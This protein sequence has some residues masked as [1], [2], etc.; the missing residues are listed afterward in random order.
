LGRAFAFDRWKD[1]DQ[2]AWQ[3]LY[4]EA[5]ARAERGR[6]RCPPLAGNDRHPGAIAIARRALQQ[7]QLTD[8]IHLDE[9]D[10]RDWQPPFAPEYVVSNPPYGERLQSDDG[11]LVDSW[12]SLGNFLHG[13]QGSTAHV[14]C[15]DASLTRHLGLR[16]ERKFPV[17]N[18][19]IECRWLRYEVGGDDEG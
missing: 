10:A 5:E 8:R 18:G 4:D 17:R 11:T 15:G 19:P 16:A 14:L 13:C 3:Q 2:N 1:T 7:A 6:D 9:G 12:R